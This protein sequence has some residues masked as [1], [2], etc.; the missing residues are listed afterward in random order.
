MK[1]F[2]AKVFIYGGAI[3]AIASVFL[4]DPY[5]PESCHKRP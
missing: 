3:V 4:I 5:M 2:D 1:G